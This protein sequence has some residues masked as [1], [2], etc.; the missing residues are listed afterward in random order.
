MV[1][2]KILKKIGNYFRNTGGYA[3]LCALN[4]FNVF[5]R[6]MARQGNDA[7]ILNKIS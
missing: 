2:L 6:M 3:Y 5:W 7:D 4:L 1:E